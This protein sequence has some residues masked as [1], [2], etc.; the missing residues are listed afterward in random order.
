MFLFPLPFFFFDFSTR[1]LLST[2]FS[3]FVTS[4]I[5]DSWTF[6]LAGQIPNLEGKKKK[7]C[8]RAS[9]HTTHT[10][11]YYL[12]VRI[13]LLILP[14]P[15][16]IDPVAKCDSR[17][18]SKFLKSLYSGSIQ[19]PNLLRFQSFPSIPF[20]SPSKRPIVPEIRHTFGVCVS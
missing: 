9:T 7:S 19:T 8:S 12:K 14:L 11:N 3:L 15:L 20:A 1:G 16:H 2:F 18:L 13:P 6:L 10:K 17:F 5:I 4:R